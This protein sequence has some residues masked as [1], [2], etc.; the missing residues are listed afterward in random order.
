M[1]KG[2]LLGIALCL[3]FFGLCLYSYL[4]LQNAVTAKRIEIPQL[5]NS[6][7][8]IQEE[9]VRLQFAIEAFE[10][11]DNLLKLAR[12]K[13]FSHLKFPLV[14]EILTLPEGLALAIP[15]PALPESS[16]SKPHIAF[17]FGATQ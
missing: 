15:Q 11:P 16:L 4:D 13:N 12:E 7:K 6:L 3:M 2:L 5:S 14:K 1:R 8:K 10:S 9:N 17:A